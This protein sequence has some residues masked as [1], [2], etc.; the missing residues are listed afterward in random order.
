MADKRRTNARRL[1]SAATVAALACG[2]LTMA[3]QM[4]SA[5]PAGTVIRV[6]I[7]DHGMY[8]NGPTTFPAGRVHLSVDASG[9]DRGVA[10]GLLSPGYTFQDFRDDVRTLGDNLFGPH[11]SKKKGLKAE[12]HLIANISSPGGLYAHEGQARHGTL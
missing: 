6:A 7:T 11:G 1:L 9:K 10:V 3:P 5:T 2:G 4:A 8:V 12:S